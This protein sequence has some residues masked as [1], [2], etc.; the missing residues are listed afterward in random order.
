M[1]EGEIEREDRR[2]RRKGIV[3]VSGG[4]GFIGEGERG[5]IRFRGMEL[6]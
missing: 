6:N 4:K 2:G 1:E 3:P 5:L